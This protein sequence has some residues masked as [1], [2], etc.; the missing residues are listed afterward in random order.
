[1]ATFDLLRQRCSDRKENNQFTY[2]NMKT[3]SREVNNIEI[4]TTNNI[5]YSI[6]DPECHLLNNTE[7]HESDESERPNEADSSLLSKLHVE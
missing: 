5:S 6:Q 4:H 7:D 3:Q 1:M 2:N